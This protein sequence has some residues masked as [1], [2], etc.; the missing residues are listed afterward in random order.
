[1]PPRRPRVIGVGALKRTL[2]VLVA[3]AALLALAFFILV[4]AVIIKLESRGPVF[5]RARRVGLGGREI[6]M[7][8]FRKMRGGATGPVLTGPD[9]ERLTR[10]G[11]FLGKT[12]LDEI[13]QLWNVLTGSMSLVGPRPQDPM[14]VELRRADYDEILQVKP[15]ITGPYQLAFARESELL[16]GT[17]H[18]AD[19]VRRML[20]VKTQFDRLYVAHRSMA[21]DLRIL[22]W[23]AVVV[24]LRTDVAVNRATGRLTRRR[25]RQAVLD[26]RHA[27][28]DP[29]HAVPEPRHAVPEPRHAVPEP[30][31]AVPEPHHAV[32]DP[33]HA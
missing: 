9:D 25:R 24:F 13:P 12:K 4:V 8:K 17:D 6:R 29:R 14:F 2:D 33:H 11:K 22:T 10:V 31:D 21:V 27:V 23:T 5:Y 28:L 3:T 15:G 7:L 19:Y 20:P 32:P 18:V 26:P 30:H 16:D 1:M